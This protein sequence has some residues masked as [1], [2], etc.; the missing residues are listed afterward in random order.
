LFFFDLG[1]WHLNRLQVCN[2]AF[3]LT[4]GLI[5]YYGF[6]KVLI[7]LIDFGFFDVQVTAFE[8]VLVELLS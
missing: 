5:D 8:P 4:C 3:D 2:F 7:V 6:P 1:F